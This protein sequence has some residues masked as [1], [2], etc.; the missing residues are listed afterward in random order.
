MNFNLMG[1]NKVLL[2]SLEECKL[3]GWY[4]QDVEEYNYEFNVIINNGFEK[5]F[6][7]SIVFQMIDELG[8]IQI[9]SNLA[10]NFFTIVGSRF[11]WPFQ[12]IKEKIL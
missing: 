8:S 10:E 2:Y 3:K 12:L 5:N 6:I 7:N 4:S 1:G 11:N 9:I